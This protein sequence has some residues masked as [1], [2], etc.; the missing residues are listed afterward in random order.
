VNYPTSSVRPLA[1]T[2]QCLFGISTSLHGLD[3]LGPLG[4]QIGET[5]RLSPEQKGLMVAMPI[6]SGA[7]LRILLGLLVD[8][9]GAKNTGI[10]AQLVS[11]R[12]WR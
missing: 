12:G 3:R 7:I 6:L 9:I 4:V 1:D 11:L 2:P 8:R 5:L 10:I